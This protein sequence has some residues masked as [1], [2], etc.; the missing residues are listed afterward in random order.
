MDLP[1]ILAVVCGLAGLYLKSGLRSRE[2]LR[3]D[4][5]DASG[6][7]PTKPLAQIRDDITRDMVMDYAAHVA[8]T[9][10][11]FGAAAMALLFK[12]LGR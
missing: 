4:H 2:L 12:L 6:F 9:C 10:G 7:P 11:C 1:L 8:L 5:G 3:W